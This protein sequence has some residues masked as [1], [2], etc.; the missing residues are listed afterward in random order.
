MERKLYKTKKYDDFMGL[1]SQGDCPICLM[2]KNWLE[3]FIDAFLYEGVNDRKMRKRIKENGGICPRHAHAMMEQGDP[4]AHA[5]IYSDLIEDYLKDLDGKKKAGCLVCDLERQS[6]EVILKSFLDFFQNSL[7]F[8]ERF[9]QTGA[10]ICRPHLKQ[11]KC[12]T[13]NKVLIQDLYRI[14]TQ[15]LERTRQ[16]LEEIKRK[17]DYR[18]SREAL[19]EEEKTAWQRAVKLMVGL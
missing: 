11:L 14:Q 1:F 9:S 2:R 13:R 15:N 16:C 6:D 18:F 12:M 17:T 10:C 7:E 8:S 5:I 19:T 4:L 3:E